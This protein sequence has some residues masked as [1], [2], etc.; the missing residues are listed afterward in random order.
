M[1]ATVNSCL[2][3]AFPIIPQTATDGI[4]EIR[5]WMLVEGEYT[6]DFIDGTKPLSK[7]DGTA[8]ASTSVGYPPQLLDLAGKP[9]VDL[10]GVANTGGVAIP[11]DPFAART[12]YLCYDVWG[13]TSNYPNFGAYGVSGSKGVT[14]QTGPIGGSTLFPRFDF[15]SGSSNIGVT[16]VNG[17][18]TAR[19]VVAFSFPTGLTSVTSC[20][21]G[22]ADRTDALTPGTGWDDGRAAT[23]SSVDGTPNRMLVFYAEHDRA[24]RLAISR[25]LGNKYGAN[26]A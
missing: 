7:W 5:E 2:Y 13:T 17:R 14:F 23:A 16:L 3:M 18:K 20:I 26:V 10:A 1:D 15:P 12:I 6:G 24:T 9:S 19:H 25:Y 4:F 21:D 8:N 22:N 11:V